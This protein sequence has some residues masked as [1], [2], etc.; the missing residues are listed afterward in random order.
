MQKS[1]LI[2][3]INSATFI[4]TNENN[5]L[6]LY[7]FIGEL[8]EKPNFTLKDIVSEAFEVLSEKNF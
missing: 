4:G 6:I 5:L 8:L 3:I 1:Q 7:N 2:A